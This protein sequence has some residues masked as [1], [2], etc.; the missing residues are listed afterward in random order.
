MLCCVCCAAGAP[1]QGA[2]HLHWEEQQVSKQQGGWQTLHIC[3]GIWQAHQGVIGP[4]CVE[5][6]HCKGGQAHIKVLCSS[7]TST[8]SSQQC[9]AV[10]E[11]RLTIRLV[12]HNINE[13]LRGLLAALDEH[14]HS[15]ESL[16]NRFPAKSQAWRPATGHAAV[17]Q[18]SCQIPP[19]SASG[20]QQ[21]GHASQ[22]LCMHTTTN[23]TSIPWRGFTYHGV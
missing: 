23:R 3:E 22:A 20:C 13:G 9:I 21:A 2:L 4:C 6:T 7:R 18:T 17:L 14:L 5:C 16:S 10:R 11:R 1:K 8:S 19:H 12:L 15:R